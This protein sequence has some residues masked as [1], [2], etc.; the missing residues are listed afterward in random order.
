MQLNVWNSRKIVN[1]SHFLIKKN[2]KPKEE[3]QNPNKESALQ[4]GSEKQ[5]LT[6]SRQRVKQ[7]LKSS[8]SQLYNSCPHHFLH[9]SF[10]T[11]TLMC[12]TWQAE[13]ST[14][15]TTPGAP[16]KRDQEAAT[17]N[18][19][20]QWLKSQLW[21]VD[22]SASAEAIHCNFLHGVCEKFWWDR[23]IF[24]LRNTFAIIQF[25]KRQCRI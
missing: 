5:L 13:T 16:D 21:E 22:S 11:C 10:Y 19:A 6:W 23:N 24:I 2:T 4:P 12:P 1:L 25:K 9:S 14:F 17:I 18:F 8:Q 3:P 7:A 15:Y 20:S